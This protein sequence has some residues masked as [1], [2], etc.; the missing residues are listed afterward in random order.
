MLLP[1]I[2]SQERVLNALWIDT[3]ERQFDR[4][5]LADETGGPSSDRSPGIITFPS[6]THA[7]QRSA[8]V[9]TTC[10]ISGVAELFQAVVP[11]I[12]GVVD[13]GHNVK[14]T[15]SRRWRVLGLR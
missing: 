4:R 13:N 1:T 12:H 14:G 15:R 11:W 9:H 8:I 5:L 7:L 3:F 10:L 6:A 2:V